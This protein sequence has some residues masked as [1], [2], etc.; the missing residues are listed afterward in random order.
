MAS[1]EPFQISTETSAYSFGLSQMLTGSEQHTL[2][3]LKQILSDFQLVIGL[4]A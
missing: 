1:Y 4:Q 2:G 3:L